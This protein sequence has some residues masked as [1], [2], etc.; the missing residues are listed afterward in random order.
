MLFGMKNEPPIYQRVVSRAFKNYF[1]KFMK[2][3]L[4]DFIVYSD[5]VTHLNKLKL[6]FQKCKEFGITLNLVNVPWK[7]YSIFKEVKWIVRTKIQ[8]IV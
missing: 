3:F 1:D 5:M 8:A 6:C 7:L 4:D 2:I